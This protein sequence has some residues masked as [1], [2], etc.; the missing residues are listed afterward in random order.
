MDKIFVYGTFTT[1]GRYYQHYVQGHKFL[2]KGFIKGY[3]KYFLGGLYGILPEE[4]K[5]VAGEV[6][7]SDPAMLAKLDHIMNND[8]VFSRKFVDVEMENGGNLQAE[9]YVWNGSVYKCETA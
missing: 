5:S 8:T 4:G 3:T 7:E 9:T 6:Y 2:G 1:N